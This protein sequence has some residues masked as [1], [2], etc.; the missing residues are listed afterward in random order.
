MAF[1]TDN[2]TLNNTPTN[3]SDLELVCITIESSYLLLRMVAIKVW[4]KPLH[5]KRKNKWSLFQPFPPDSQ[6]NSRE[7]LNFPIISKDYCVRFQRP[8]GTTFVK[9]KQPN[10]GKQVLRFSSP[11]PKQTVVCILLIWVPKLGPIPFSK[12]PPSEGGRFLPKLSSALQVPYVPD[13]I[14]SKIWFKAVVQTTQR[15]RGDA[16]KK[17]KDNQIPGRFGLG[18]FRD[19]QSPRRLLRGRLGRVRCRTATFSWCLKGPGSGY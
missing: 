4:A 5:H 9:N 2:Q 14:G 7:F 8:S 18:P 19:L 12:L 11:F 17:E 1:N 13:A 6:T 10:I 3:K 15:T 16:N